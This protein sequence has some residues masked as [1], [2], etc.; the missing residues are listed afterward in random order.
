MDSRCER[1]WVGRQVG[2]GFADPLLVGVSRI[3]L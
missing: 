3:T 2:A 1:G